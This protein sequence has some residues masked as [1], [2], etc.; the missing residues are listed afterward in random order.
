MA[1]TT[2]MKQAK[3]KSLELMIVAFGFV[4]GGV[5]KDAIV[6]WLA[7]LSPGEEATAMELTVSAV[8]VTAVVVLLIIALTKVLGEKEEK[9]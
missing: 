6:R 7:G 1:V 8:I 2:V 4:A 3:A 9:A 5:W